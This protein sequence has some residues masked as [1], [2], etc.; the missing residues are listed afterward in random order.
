MRAQQ[1]SINVKSFVTI[2][3]KSAQIVQEDGECEQELASGS[4]LLSLTNLTY[5]IVLIV[6][7]R[8]N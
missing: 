5:N 3:S 4:E 1:K 6:F 8:F 7:S 2:M